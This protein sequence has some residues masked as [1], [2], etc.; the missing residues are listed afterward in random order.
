MVI[1]SAATFCYVQLCLRGFMTDT[2]YATVKDILNIMQKLIG[3]GYAE[4]EVE[5]N[6]EYALA[7]PDEIPKINHKTKTVSLGGYC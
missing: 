4:Y 3:D 2:K 5:C 1:Q 6:Q 7:K